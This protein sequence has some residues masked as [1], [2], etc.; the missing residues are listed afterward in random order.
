MLTWNLTVVAVLVAV[1]RL[2]AWFYIRRYGRIEGLLLADGLPSP[3]G[4]LV[5][6]QI[7]EDEAVDEL[8]GHYSFTIRNVYAETRRDGTFTFKGVRAGEVTLGRSYGVLT[9]HRESFELLPVF[10][11]VDGSQDHERVVFVIGGATVRVVLGEGGRVVRGQMILPEEFAP[12]EIEALAGLSSLWGDADGPEAPKGLDDAEREAW[13]KEVTQTPEGRAWREATSRGYH[14]AADAKGHFE[15]RN[16]A[17][18]NY[19][20]RCIASMGLEEGGVTGKR[21]YAQSIRIAVPQ[22]HGEEDGGVEIG[23]LTLEVV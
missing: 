6:C 17:P 2:L 16:V 4:T 12:I 13:W 9:R 18:G 3:A 23:V 1:C 11:D 7:V 5:A 10:E 8:P 22:A 19:R 15:V 21:I 14:V 20:L